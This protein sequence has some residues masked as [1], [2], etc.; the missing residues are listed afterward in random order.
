MIRKT[1]LSLLCLVAPLLITAQIIDFDALASMKDTTLPDSIVFD[2]SVSLSASFEKQK[3]QINTFSGKASSAIQYKHN[4]I[5]PVVSQEII[6]TGS[7]ELQNTGHFSIKYLYGFQN[8]F[9]Y[10]P[11]SQ[12]QWDAQRGMQQRFLYGGNIWLNVIR[13]ENFQWTFAAGFFSEYEKWDYT[14]VS[15]ED[16]PNPEPEFIENTFFKYNAK[17]RVVWRFSKNSSVS[18]GAFVQGRPDFPEYL[19]IA[20]YGKLVLEIRKHLFFST[21]FEG[22]YDY[23][24]IVPI[25][26]FYFTQE[27]TLIF[28]F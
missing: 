16:R 22:I 27:N 24:P 3:Q 18:I 21:G 25:D 8:R 23:K 9:F 10:E 20:P 2:G 26:H 13:G 4:L 7:S 14:A 28:R 15:E 6:T 5:I 12:Y 19:R 11:Y 1:L 17:T